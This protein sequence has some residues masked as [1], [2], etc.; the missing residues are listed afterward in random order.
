MEGLDGPSGSERAFAFKQAMAAARNG[1]VGLVTDWLKT[2]HIDE[3]EQGSKSD[4]WTLLHAA[5]AADR[6]AVVELLILKRACVNAVTFRGQTALHLAALDSQEEICKMLLQHSCNPLLRTSRKLGCAT[7]RDLAL[8]FGRHAVAS[9]LEQ[10]EKDYVLCDDHASNP[11]CIASSSSSSSSSRNRL[12]DFSKWGNTDWD[13]VERESDRNL[14]VPTARRPAAL[15]SAAAAAAAAASAAEDVRKESAA[16]YSSDPNRLLS[17]RPPPEGGLQPNAND[18]GPGPSLPPLQ[19]GGGGGVC[20][21]WGQT[22]KTL[23]IVIEVGVDV[24]A[25]DIKIDFAPNSISISIPARLPCAHAWPAPMQL[26][27]AV[28]PH[29]CTWS[30]DGRGALEVL[31][32]KQQPSYWRCVVKGHPVIDSTMCRGPDVL[33]QLDDEASKSDAMKVFSKMLSRLK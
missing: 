3:V 6:K 19:G 18:G 22:M 25:K 1:N 33:S 11:A 13:A 5:A 21:T 24:C 28:F 20:Y 8:L 29:D 30:L 26:W 9:L 32:E 14:S 15:T 31:L 16:S 7:A 23:S 10:A 27:A 12:A 17:F 4:G 2:G